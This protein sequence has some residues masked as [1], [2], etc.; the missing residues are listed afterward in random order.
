MRVIDEYLA[1]QALSGDWPPGLPDDDVLAL[2]NY[3]HWRLLAAL[4]AGRGGQLSRAMDSLSPS[5]R[6]AIR[7]PDPYLV[8]I[9]DPRPLM[10]RAAQINAR[11]GGG[12]LL[13]CETAAAAIDHGNELWFGRAQNVGRRLL[14]IARAMGIEVHIL[15]R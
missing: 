15:E 12:G 5:T 6:E 4:D 7:E 3:V 14:D 1:I 8:T 13:V 10:V 2:P 11:F 9:L